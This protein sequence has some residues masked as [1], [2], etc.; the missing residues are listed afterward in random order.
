MSTNV[1]SGARA[2]FRLN[3]QKVAFA[4]GC[5]GSE[6]IMYEPVDVLDNLEVQEF[7]P[8]GYRVTFTCAIFRTIKGVDNAKAPREGMYGSMKEMGIFPSIL[9][10]QNVLT[11]GTMTAVLIDRLTH[12]TVAQVEEVKCASYNWTI[13]ARGIVGQ[14]VTFNAIRIKDETEAGGQ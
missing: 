6:E 5:D 14:N 1:F 9:D 4:S 11:K 3:G 10:L 13:S 12:K 8:V 7:V 2:I